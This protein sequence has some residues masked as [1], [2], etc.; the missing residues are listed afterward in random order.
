MSYRERWTFYHWGPGL[1]DFT[2]IR[3]TNAKWP[4]PQFVTLA[5]KRGYDRFNPDGTLFG[6]Y[7]SNP[8]G[9]CLVIT[10]SGVDPVEFWVG[11]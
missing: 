7:F 2:R 4:V 5:E 8:S 1:R 3:G 9:D 10:P 11:G 6:G